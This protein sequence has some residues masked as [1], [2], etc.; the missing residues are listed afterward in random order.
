MKIKTNVRAGKGG[1]KDKNSGKSSIN[2]TVIQIASYISRCT[3]I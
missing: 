3:G 2:N 1:S